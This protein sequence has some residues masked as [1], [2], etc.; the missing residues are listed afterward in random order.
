MLGTRPGLSAKAVSALNQQAP[1]SPVRS[2]DR[3]DGA[4]ISTDAFW[5]WT[6]WYTPTVPAIQK[7]EVRGSL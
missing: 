1:R 7:A 6:R 4:G 3:G 5:S 2:K